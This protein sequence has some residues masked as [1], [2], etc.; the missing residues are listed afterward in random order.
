MTKVITDGLK[1]S[2][3]PPQKEYLNAFK[4]DMYKM[5]R[6]IEF[7]KVRNDFQDKLKEDL[8][9]IRSSKTVLT[10]IYMNCTRRVMR[11]CYTII[12][13]KHTKKRL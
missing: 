12:S 13:H 5:I 7:I 1:T 4:N 10:Q 2:A 8:E 6:K 11:Y 3:T 9:I